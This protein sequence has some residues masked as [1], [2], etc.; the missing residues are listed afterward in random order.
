LRFPCIPWELV[1]Q[2][3]QNLPVSEN[4]EFKNLEW[5]DF[6]N[7][8]YGCLADDSIIRY[9]QGNYDNSTSTKTTENR[10]Y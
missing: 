5:H 9:P 7:R 1:K 8:T 3:Y 6:I 10:T 2:A 4:E